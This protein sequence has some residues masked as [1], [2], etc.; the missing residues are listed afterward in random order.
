MGKPIIIIGAKVLGK[1]ALEIFN[2]NEIIL[3][4]P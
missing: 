3:M 2:N 4:D 1:S